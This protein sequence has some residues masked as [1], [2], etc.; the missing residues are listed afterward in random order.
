MVIHGVHGQLY[1]LQALGE[2]PEGKAQSRLVFIVKSQDKAGI[3][4]LFL[5]TRKARSP[6]WKSSSEPCSAGRC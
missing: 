3:A 6:V 5:D 2:W 1:P 4:R